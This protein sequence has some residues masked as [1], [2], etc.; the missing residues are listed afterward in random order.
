MIAGGIPYIDNARTDGH[1][2]KLD[3]LLHAKP[4]DVERN[5]YKQQLLTLASRRVGIV[6]DYVVRVYAFPIRISAH[7]L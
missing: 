4:P 7:S 6:R 5:N 2:K 1:R 3:T